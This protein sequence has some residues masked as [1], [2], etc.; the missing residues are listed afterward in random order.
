MRHSLELSASRAED[1]D[2]CQLEHASISHFIDLRQVERPS[3]W[4]VGRSE[5]ERRRCGVNH[6]YSHDVFTRWNSDLKASVLVGIGIPCAYK[7]ILSVCTC[8]GN[9][10]A[11]VF[12]TVRRNESALDVSSWQTYRVWAELRKIVP[13]AKIFS[14]HIRDRYQF[15]LH[16]IPVHV[17]VASLLSCVVNPADH[18]RGDLV[19]IAAHA[20]RLTGTGI[21]FCFQ[22]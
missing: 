5:G 17:P 21:H 8:R 11:L 1:L 9:P 12:L 22:Q 4:G 10:D 15:E 3:Y 20:H 18:C 19:T 14:C 16:S 6:V 2:R 7:F 13:S